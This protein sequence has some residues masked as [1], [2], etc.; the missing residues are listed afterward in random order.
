VLMAAT[1]P[2]QI[3]DANNWLHHPNNAALKGDALVAALQPLPWDPSVKSLVAFPQILRMMDDKLEWTE[4]LGNAF[5]AQQGDVMDAIQRLRYQAASAGTLWSSAQQRVMTEGQGIAIEPTNPA[6]IYPPV[7]NPDLV[8]GPWPDQD[9]P[10]LDLVPPDYDVGFGLLPFGIGFGT[11]FV[12]IQP[13]R[14]AFDWTRR[15][16]LLHVDKSDAFDRDEQARRS[17]VWQHDP[18][19]RHGVSYRDFASRERFGGFRDRPVSVAVLPRT[20][21]SSINAAR[22]TVLRDPAPRAYPAFGRG[23]PARSY[24]QRGG[25]VGRMNAPRMMA[26]TMGRRPT[27]WMPARAVTASGARVSAGAASTGGGSHR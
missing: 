13:C 20:A 16:L 12:V 2:Q 24:M 18:A 7:Y 6:L 9:Y 8:Y 15:K 26:W 23:L 14:C 4:Q 11:G 1:F 21:I 19:H 17:E 5:L 22:A 25:A 10:P 27:G 3:I